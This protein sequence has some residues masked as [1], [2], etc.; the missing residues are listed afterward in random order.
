MT[1][2]TGSGSHR[3]ERVPADKIIDVPARSRTVDVASA[4]ETTEFLKRLHDIVSRHREG[5]RAYKAALRAFL[6][7]IDPATRRRLARG[8]MAS[9]PG[10][11]PD[12][13]QA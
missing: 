3:E 12:I 1:K 13:G 4:S 11:R 2:G 10:P 8:I 7:D 9:L 5:S 6:A